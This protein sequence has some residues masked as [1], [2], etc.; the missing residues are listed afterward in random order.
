M[1]LSII[2]ILISFS[3]MAYSQGYMD[4]A[5]NLTSVVA[6]YPQFFQDSIPSKADTITIS[7]AHQT[8]LPQ[9][10]KQQAELQQA[11]QD[12][13]DKIMILLT[14]YVDPK[15]ISEGKVSFGQDSKIIVR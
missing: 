3:A 9:L 2:A 4:N 14:A 8:L 10:M 5:L 12:I 15:K 7:P 13:Q 1:K 6:K 11:M